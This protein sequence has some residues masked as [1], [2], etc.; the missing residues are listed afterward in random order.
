MP[1]VLS[2]TAQGLPYG[3][4]Q[5]RKDPSFLLSSISLLGPDPQDLG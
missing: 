3:A 1:H 5:H 4:Y 2:L